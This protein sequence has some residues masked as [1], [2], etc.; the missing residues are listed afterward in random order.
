M[1]REV[2]ENCT[3]TRNKFSLNRLGVKKGEYGGVSVMLKTGMKV[4]Q[5]YTVFKYVPPRP[6]KDIKSKYRTT[7]TG[8]EV[9]L[10]PIFLP[11]NSKE[12]FGKENLQMC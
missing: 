10:A 5:H 8:P 4:S 9:N 3:T 12:K 11:G 6:Q 2:L 1:L 7:V